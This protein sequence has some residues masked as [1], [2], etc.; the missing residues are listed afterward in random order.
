[1]LRALLTDIRHA[2]RSLRR[3][4]TLVAVVLTTMA[5]G[6][7]ASTVVFTLVDAIVLRALPYDHPDR[8][9]WVW[10]AQVQG[11]SAA[12]LEWLQRDS[13]SYQSI[14]SWTEGSYK[15]VHDDRAEIVNGPLVSAE[16]LNVLGARPV[17]G[18]SLQAGDDKYG[19]RV[20]VLSHEYWQR[21]FGADPN[22]VGRTMEL[23]GTVY[24]IVGVIEPEF[25][26]LQR[27]VDVVVPLLAESA[28]QD[29]GANYLSLVARLAPGASVES[30]S[31]ELLALATARAEAQGTTTQFAQTA[32]V[33]SL[34]DALIGNLDVTLFMLLGAVGLMMLIVVANVANLLLVR[35]IGRE[36]ETALRLALG[37]HWGAVT[38]L[39]LTES[40]LLAGAGGLLGIATA[41]AGVKFLAG[42]LPIATPRVAGASIDVRILGFSLAVT[43]VTGLVI[44]LFPAITALGTDIRTRIGTGNR[45]A[46]VRRHRIKSV[47]VAGEVALAVVLLMGAGLLIRSFR[48]TLDIDPGF[49][50]QGLSHFEI[51]PGT[52][53][54]DSGEALNAYY[55]RIKERV[56]ALPGVA[57]VALVHAVPIRNPGWRMGVYAE[58]NPRA[59]GDPVILSN[60]RPVSTEY[61][62][63]AG[64]TLKSGR[65]FTTD[66]RAGGEQVAVLNETAA[67]TLF[68]DGNPV[69]RRVVMGFD[70][71]DPMRVIGVI[72][73]VRIRGLRQSP[74]LALYRPYAQ[75]SDMMES[76]TFINRSVMIR[77]DLD[78]ASL[79]RPVEEALS[80]LDP[81]ASVLRVESM[82]AVL[83]DSL[84]E[85]RTV[86]WL[87]TGFAGVALLLGAI[88]IYGVLAQAV[89]ERSRELSIRLALGAPRQSL[90]AMVVTEGMK[91]TAIGFLAG[92]ALSWWLTR[93]IEGQLFDIGRHDA[94]TM[95][96]SGMVLVFA[97]LLAAYLPARR[98]GT[99][100]PMEL[101][102]GE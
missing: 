97:A 84:A 23:E 17:M 86:M 71:P 96:A 95:L 1:M 55:R 64:L 60:W 101:L 87:L 13:R 46:G 67:T 14:A 41:F 61:L 22:I 85:A 93:F 92:G 81:L 43:L 3:Q 53:D 45:S 2:L 68:G 59:P 90:V 49:R 69:G 77:S 100:D 34:R 51:D 57:S 6:I 18:R 80:E 15:F 94:S 33:S 40:G 19:D 16:F 78:V 26:Y 29:Y 31:D 98:A 74:P 76:R 37:A 48:A 91:L 54:F 72:Q 28:Q 21:G 39:L 89:G 30:A 99:V 20:V 79:I 5:F 58:D 44:G 52:E 24:T 50:L 65:W 63:T 47:L 42:I 38:R 56:A 25:D 83:A 9:A 66:D 27:D 82:D 88:G 36:R 32:S 10:P 7:G 102:K 8:L 75:T 70:T 35:A 62:E 73:D 4:P 12:T 11:T